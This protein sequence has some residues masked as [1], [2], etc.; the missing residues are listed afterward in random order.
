MAQSEALRFKRSVGDTLQ[1]LWPDRHGK[2]T[3]RKEGGP[4][5]VLGLIVRERVVVSSKSCL[6]E[7]TPSS[8]MRQPACPSHVCDYPNYV[9]QVPPYG[10]AALQFLS[11]SGRA[12]TSQHGGCVSVSAHKNTRTPPGMQ[13]RYPHRR[14]LF[15]RMRRH[16]DCRNAPSQTSNRDVCA[17][18]RNHFSSLLPQLF[19]RSGV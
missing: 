14:P 16:R 1:H 3:D 19:A 15:P 11:G 8:L 6:T 7:P 10:L 4:R 13:R 17:T 18:R 5:F 12:A 2:D 9:A